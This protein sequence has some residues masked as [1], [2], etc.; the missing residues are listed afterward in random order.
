M[1]KKIIANII[2]IAMTCGTFQNY[3][4]T[5]NVKAVESV[6]EDVD[7]IENCITNSGLKYEVTDKTK[8]TVSITGYDKDKLSKNLIIPEIIK[9]KATGNEYKVDEI[10]KSAF[11]GAS[12]ESVKFANTITKIKSSSFNMCKQLKEVVLNKGLEFIGAYSFNLCERLEE[13]EIPSTVKEMDEAV[14]AYCYELKKVTFNETVDA[15]GN[16]EGL[17]KVNGQSDYCSK[18]SIFNACTKIE[19]INIPSTLQE[20]IEMLRLEYSNNAEV[21]ISSP[22]DDFSNGRNLYFYNIVIEEGPTIIGSNAFVNTDVKKISLPSSLNYI[23]EGAFK[24]CT[25]LSDVSMAKDESG[26]VA[27]CNISSINRT[28]FEGCTKITDKN[29]L[30]NF[31]LSDYKGNTKTVNS[32]IQPSSEE[33]ISGDFKYK[34][35]SNKA[36]ITGISES[37]KTKSTIKIPEEIDGMP[38]Y[39]IGDKAFYGNKSIDSITISNN[40]EV[41]GKSAFEGCK[42]RYAYINNA[43]NLR[44]IQDK[45]FKDSGLESI[46]FPTSIYRINDEVFANCKSLGSVSFNNST[47]LYYIGNRAFENCKYISSINLSKCKSLGDIGNEAFIECTGLGTINLPETLKVIND[48]AFK[49]CTKISQ[50][51]CNTALEVLGNGAFEN[52]SSL[53]GVTLNDSL[54]SIGSNAF[55]G[56]NLDKIEIPASVKDM[57]GSLSNSSISTVVLN[58]KESIVKGAFYNTSN[59]ENLTIQDSIKKIESCAFYKA[60]NLKNITINNDEE[61]TIKTS[62]ENFTLPSNVNEIEYNAFRDCSDIK[63]L[64]YSDKL[65][66]IGNEAFENCISLSGINETN[67]KSSF[68]SVKTIGSKT[69]KDCKSLKNINASELKNIT[70]G[71]YVFD[72]SGFQNYYR[73]DG[74]TMI[75][76]DDLQGY[77]IISC[78][79][80]DSSISILS[81]I[82]DYDNIVAIGNNV[83]ENNKDVKTVNI[84]KGI[85]HIGDNAFNGC[86]ELSNVVE[87]LAEGNSEYTIPSTVETV[88]SKAFTNTSIKEIK[89]YKNTNIKE[90]SFNSDTIINCDG[91]KYKVVNIDEQI[92][93]EIVGYDS[94]EIKNATNLSLPKESNGLKVISVANKVFSGINAENIEIST[95]IIK[96]G[97][98]A[99]KDNT[100]VK[101]LVINSDNINIGT[102]AFRGCTE[103]TSVDIKG[104]VNAIGDR[105]FYSCDKIGDTI[106]LSRSSIDSKISQSAFNNSPITII[107]IGDDYVY[108]FAS[109][110]T[111]KLVSYI[112]GES[113]PTIPETINQNKL[114]TIGAGAFRDNAKITK[115]SLS[116]NI[117]TIEDNAFFN[118]TSLKGI[119]APKVKYVGF[120]ILGQTSCETSL[121][122]NS[123]LKYINI[124]NSAIVT[125]YINPNDSRKKLEIPSALGN[126]KVISIDYRAFA[127]N[128]SINELVLP[129]SLVSI[130]DEAFDGCS[131]LVG[132]IPSGIKVGTNAF[133]NNI[134]RETKGDYSYY[135][136]GN[137]IEIVQYLG[138]DKTIKEITIPE[139][140][141]GKR[142]TRIAANAFLGYTNLEVVTNFNKGNKS[143]IVSVDNDAFLGTALINKIYDNYIYNPTTRT[144][145]GYIGTNSEIIIPS[146][147]N[148]SKIYAIG[149]SAFKDN[150]NLKKVTISGGITTIENKAFSGCSNLEKVEKPSTVTKVAEDAYEGT[151]VNKDTTSGSG[152]E[153]DNKTENQKPEET[154]DNSKLPIVATIL[155]L[156]GFTISKKRR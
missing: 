123:G 54:I 143:N 115:V 45:A 72:G 78:D 101:N 31:K 98:G 63:K 67:D 142:V 60:S 141:D 134:E 140:I 155:S 105:A 4:F 113:T 84:D 29:Q 42:L 9:D 66:T 24:D 51:K 41:I 14:F 37:G 17:I 32:N 102:E 91:Y 120:N 95:S 130:S 99:F 96:I 154:A 129:S 151:K 145:I 46:A 119:V 152:S 76:N 137:T 89:L 16:K 33:I 11:S 43:N 50:I 132:T 109:E 148:G 149:E 156:V 135:V 106:K 21:Y 23:S 74:F 112:G 28:A 93:L 139:E 2:L 108:S 26:T 114:T 7:K 69:F 55:K 87:L 65:Y 121:D 38:V 13:I 136:I 110:D 77:E 127:G 82:G 133:R 153:T 126:L 88:G 71:D 104:K 70:L 8:K 27:T 138:Q 19:K 97:D 39:A 124:G 90:D 73:A 44:E 58:N 56:S 144:I 1:N 94:E 79:K 111:I 64:S 100:K 103:L 25:N 15:N 20:G 68:K 3:V 57:F 12:I 81:K 52:C 47:S 48:R 36:V 80:K 49:G 5:K 85:K 118:C 131:N 18:P 35:Y 86:S 128:T 34:T 30:G 83:F 62:L 40:V 10:G 146:E 92:G 53:K 75:N 22:C 125:G 61:E 6:V 117:E 116:N 122:N 59:V 147:I 107:Q 150:T